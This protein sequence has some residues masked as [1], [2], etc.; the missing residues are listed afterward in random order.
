MPLSNIIITCADSSAVPVDIANKPL[1]T[2]LWLAE[3]GVRARTF[4][5]CGMGA[6]CRPYCGRLREDIRGQTGSRMPSAR[7]EALMPDTL[8]ISSAE[9]ALGANRQ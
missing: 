1:F 6:G 3:S 8:E 9:E 2:N 4:G 5:R 7:V